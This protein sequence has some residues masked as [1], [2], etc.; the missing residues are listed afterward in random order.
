MPL[1][2]SRR[3]WKDNNKMDVTG[4]GWSGMD[5]ITVPQDRD[6]WWVLVNTNRRVLQNFWVTVEW[7]TGGVSRRT[8]I[9]GV[10]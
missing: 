10:S 4:I 9:N 1:G 5:W 6:Q 8:Q 7:V 3:R 2:R